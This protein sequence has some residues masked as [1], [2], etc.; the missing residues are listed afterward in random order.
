MQMLKNIFSSDKKYYLELDEEKDSEVL[1]NVVETASKVTST[2]KEKATAVVESQPVQEG[3]ETATEV[4]ETAQE[5]L[6][7]VTTE[8]KS[9]KTKSGKA[10]KNGKAA[11]SAKAAESTKVTPKNSGASSF[12]PPFWVAAMYKNN[13]ASASNN[14]ATNGAETFSTDNLMPTVTKYRRSPGGSL[15]K[16][17]DMA[18][19][20]RTS[21][22]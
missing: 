19:N 11:K 14:G 13:G 12:D 4:A 6:A 5:Q 7:S 20:V 16:F 18:K 17:K 3:V 21:R 8:E 9:A 1:Q 2:V 15:N 22:R 10:K